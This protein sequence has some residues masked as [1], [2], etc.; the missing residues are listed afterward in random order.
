VQPPQPF[1]AVRPV[2][3]RHDEA[4]GIAVLGRQRGAVQL[5]GEQNVAGGQPPQRQI[6]DVPVARRPGEVAPV[7]PIRPQEPRAHIDPDLIEQRGEIDAAPTDIDYAARRHARLE[8]TAAALMHRLD[9]FLGPRFQVVE[10]KGACAAH[11]PVDD[12]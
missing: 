2:K 10:A 5:V 9:D 8:R 3:A 12:E 1:D 4:H 7:E 11:E 6:L